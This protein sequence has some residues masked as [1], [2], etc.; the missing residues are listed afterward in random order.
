MTQINE[1]ALANFLKYQADGD[2][3]DKDVI[4]VESIDEWNK[5]F[6]CLYKYKIY[7]QRSGLSLKEWES[8]YRRCNNNNG[9]YA[10]RLAS[11]INLNHSSSDWMIAN[12]IEDTNGKAIHFK[13]IPGVHRLNQFI[14]YDT[15]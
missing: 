14:L 6:E 3:I 9:D 8:V 10:L 1:K 7:G 12:Y 4:I 15:N 5:I 2:N 13:D 11:E